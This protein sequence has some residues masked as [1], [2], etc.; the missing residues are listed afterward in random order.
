MGPGP[1]IKFEMGFSSALK[2]DLMPPTPQLAPNAQASRSA[3]SSR[4]VSRGVVKSTG[5]AA[6]AEGAV[7]FVDVSEKGPKGFVVNAV[8]LSSPASQGVDC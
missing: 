1:R 8:S 4:P 6:A 5:D 7:Q 2:D 3:P